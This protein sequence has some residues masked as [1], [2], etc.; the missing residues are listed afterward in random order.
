MQPGWLEVPRRRCETKAGRF[1]EERRFVVLASMRRRKIRALKLKRGATKC[2]PNDIADEVGV[3]LP[4]IAGV[5]SAELRHRNSRD[6]IGL[7]PRRRRLAR[8]WRFL[9]VKLS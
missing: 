7:R 5:E 2:Q 3:W 4:V 1:L 6:T 8:R 9:L